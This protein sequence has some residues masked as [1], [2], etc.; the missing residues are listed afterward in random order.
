[1]PTPSIPVQLAG[2]YF[3]SR[4]HDWNNEQSVFARMSIASSHGARE[5]K[6]PNGEE[7]RL[8]FVQPLP[9]ALI[10]ALQE[11]TSSPAY[12]AD[13][14]LRAHV[15]FIAGGVLRSL[16]R[17]ADLARGK[18]NSKD[19]RDSIWHDLWVPMAEDC[20]R[21]LAAIPAGRR[22]MAAANSA[23]DLVRGEL[24]WSR[25][26][27][28]YDDGLV[29]RKESS[30]RVMPVSLVAAAVILQTAAAEVRGGSVSLSSKPAGAERGYELEHQLRAQINPCVTTVPSKLLDGTVAASLQLR[31]S[32]VL[33]FNVLHEV[34]PLIVSVAYVPLNRNFACDAIMMP[35]EYDAASP[36]ILLESSTT[37]PLDSDRVKKVRK[38]FEPKGVATTLRAAYPKRRVV[39]ALVWDQALRKRALS[40]SAAELARAGSGRAA[41]RAAAR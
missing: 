39:C 35:A 8:R 3:V 14:Q 30:S 23:L 26:K 41:D 34:K 38:W 6:L 32:C 36:I 25:A 16:V 5:L 1:V 12:I 40:D 24:T 9:P 29:A 22:R 2:R 10:K 19:V 20:S 28:L 27:P 33:P 7:R 4:W 15:A 21:W 31:A 37:D 17:G 11:D 18:R 13:K